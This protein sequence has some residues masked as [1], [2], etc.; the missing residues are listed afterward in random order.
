MSPP[1]H[2]RRAP[3]TSL[4]GIINAIHAIR[5]INTGK[6]QHQEQFRV[7]CL[8]QGHSI[9]W[10]AGPCGIKQTPLV[11]V[12]RPLQHLGPPTPP[13]PPP[14]SGAPFSGSKL[15]YTHRTSRQISLVQQLCAHRPLHPERTQTQFSHQS[16]WAPGC[17]P[18]P[19]TPP[20]H[21]CPINCL[22]WVKETKTDSL[23]FVREFLLVFFG[24]AAN[25]T[26]NERG[27]QLESDHV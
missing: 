20:H 18:P 23:C 3:T 13:Q 19:S 2:T 7:Q 10:T 25:K 6:R 1:I 27:A 21:L 22:V 12:E 8:A 16:M 5:H 26:A 9:V 11:S 4:G 17:R 14:P 15:V 24:F